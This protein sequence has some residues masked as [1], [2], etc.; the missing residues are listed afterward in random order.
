MKENTGKF[1][2]SRTEGYECSSLGDVRFSALIARMPDGRS[3]EA[4]YQC[5]VKGY[6]PGSRMWR[7]YKGLPPA[8]KIEP[9]ELFKKYVDLWRTYL[10]ERPGL[11]EEL[12][13]NVSQREY[14][15][16]DRFATTSIN[17]AHAL[18]VILNETEK[19]A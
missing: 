16:R 2:W 5:D 10:K 4:H 6:N 1:R 3:L 11:L 18:C 17:Q 19:Q 14:V 15:L 9:D 7:M 13:R 8:Y 12:R